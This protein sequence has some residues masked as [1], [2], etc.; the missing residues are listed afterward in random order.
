MEVH[1]GI[2]LEVGDIYSFIIKLIN[3]VDSDEYAAEDVMVAGAHE[4]FRF[5]QSVEF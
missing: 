2:K 3:D 5:T 1:E 4:E